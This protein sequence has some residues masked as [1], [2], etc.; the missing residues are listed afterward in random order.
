MELFLAVVAGA[1]L[2]LILSLNEALGIEGFKLGTFISHNI[3]PTVANMICG[4]VLVW[5]KEDIAEVL[6]ITGI[7]AVFLGYSGQ[8]IIKKIFK[9]FDTR[10]ETYV[11][12]NP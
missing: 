3:L 10:F 7:V 12:R 6:P 4:F 8:N 2:Y 11:G 1:F 5:F 9:V